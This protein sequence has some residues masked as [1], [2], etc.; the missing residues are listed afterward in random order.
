MATVL[1][2]NEPTTVTVTAPGTAVESPSPGSHRSQHRRGWRDMRS[3]LLVAGT[4]LVASI[5]AVAVAYALRGSSAPAGDIQATTVNFKI[6]M[7]TTLTA[8]KHTI[9]LTNSGN[10]GHEI[11]LFKTDLAAND[12][13]L[14]P[15]GDVN[16]ESPQLTSVADSGSAL[17]PGAT[18][19]FK[20]DNLSPGHYVAVCN[21]PG[22]YRLGMKVNITVH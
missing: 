5:I 18:E 16:E 8:G 14:K 13:P 17:K 1:A 20:T 21:L 10:V 2:P 11:V 12:L 19:S 4:V 9:G 22:H 15:D 3:T 6:A 7:P